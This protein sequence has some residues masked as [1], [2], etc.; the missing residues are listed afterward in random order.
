MWSLVDF[1]EE[2]E[3]R[4]VETRGVKDHKKNHRIN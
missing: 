3:G 2:G 4:I 1:A